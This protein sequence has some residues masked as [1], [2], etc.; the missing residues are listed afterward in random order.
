MNLEQLATRIRAAKILAAMAAGLAI[1]WASAVSLAATKTVTFGWED[2]T[3]TSTFEIDGDNDFNDLPPLAFMPDVGMIAL[4]NVAGGTMTDF[5][6]SGDPFPE[7]INHPVTPQEGSRM[8]EVTLSQLTNN[9]GTD[10]VVYMGFLSGLDPGD[11]YSMKFYA[12]DPTDGRSPS[13]PPNATYSTEAMPTGFNG[14]AVPLQQFLTGSG[15]LESNLDAD[16]NANTG[17]NPIIT[18]SPSAGADAVR[19]EADF[20][21]QSLAADNLVSEKFYI[22]NLTIS[23]TS[24]NPDARICLVDGTCVLV[25]EP[26]GVD[27]DYNDDGKV[28]AADY[29]VF[30]K[31]EG[32]ATTLPNDP[33]GG[34]IDSDQ[35][36]TWRANFGEMAGSGSGLASGAVPEPAGLLLMAIGLVGLGIGRSRKR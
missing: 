18:Y 2:G 27:G 4:A 5:G 1:T 12:F 36:N 11:T 20:F 3:S 6:P 35:Y 26:V 24:N 33:H 10:A 16:G 21:Y 31:H 17:V 19:V 30:R 32:T 7:P 13:I 22:D 8:L 25:N 28:D 23:V 14:F 29:V 34:T 9:G 15:W